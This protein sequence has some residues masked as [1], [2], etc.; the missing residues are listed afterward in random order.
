MPLRGPWLLG[1]LGRKLRY[2]RL[3]A[4]GRPPHVLRPGDRRTR[5]TWATSSTSGSL[6]DT[7][8]PELEIRGPSKTKTKREKAAATFTLKASER[9]GRRCRI[10]S[11]RFKPCSWRYRTPKLG[12]GTHTLK[13]KATDRGRQRGHEAQEV[14]DREEATDGSAADGRKRSLSS[15][16]SRSRR[17]PDRLT[18]R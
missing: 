17:D 11:R 13:V 2:R 8:A 1:L 9:V 5:E 4:L 10:D 7:A 16:V 18:P 15:A 14:Q 6:V 3:A 12:R